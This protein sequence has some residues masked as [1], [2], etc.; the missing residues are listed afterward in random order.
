[1][2]YEPEYRYW[3]G[4]D[5]GGFFDD[6]G[7]G[8]DDDQDDDVDEDDD[9]GGDEEDEEDQP[10]EEEGD[11][12][13]EQDPDADDG[14]GGDD[15][16]DGGDDDG[17]DDIND[18]F[19]DPDDLVSLDDDV[20]LSA[21]NFPNASE[22]DFQEDEGNWTPDDYQQS[23]ANLF[24]DHQFFGDTMLTQRADGDS[25]MSRREAR[26][27]Y[28][29]SNATVSFRPSVSFRSRCSNICK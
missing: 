20:A 19:S 4:D 17:D 14:A 29:F 5:E 11:E 1:M 10:D 7:D 2:P 15:G 28:G 16:S 13:E 6:S 25:T 9:Q 3:M 22:A 27:P 8:G 12:E 18:E 23:A 24:G 26:K 21:D